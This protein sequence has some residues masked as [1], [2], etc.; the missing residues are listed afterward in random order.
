MLAAFRGALAKL[1]WT[2]G[3]N[4]LIEYHWGGGD[5]DKMRGQAAQLATLVPDVIFVSG[6]LGLERLLKVTRAVPIVFAIVPDPLGS[7]FV[8][9]LSQSASRLS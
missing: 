7:G 2:E 6:G 5:A 4:L 1:G 8:E 3:S 9:S